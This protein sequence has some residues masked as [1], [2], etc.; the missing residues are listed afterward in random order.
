MFDLLVH[1]FIRIRIDMLVE[2]TE[3]VHGTGKDLKH[4]EEMGG[5]LVPLN[6]TAL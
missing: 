1:D 5:H 6:S 3:Q 4:S 2:M